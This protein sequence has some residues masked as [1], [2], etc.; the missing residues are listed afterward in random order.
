MEKVKKERKPRQPKADKPR[1][2]KPK[3]DKPKVSKPKAV[4]PKVSKPKTYKPSKNIIKLDNA[5]MGGQS[6]QNE[7]WFKPSFQKDIQIVTKELSAKIKKVQDNSK[8][9]AEEKQKKI[10]KLTATNTKVLLDLARDYKTNPEFFKK[11]A[12]K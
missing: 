4:K 6:I 8:L 7:D 9:S 12:K 10:K 5:L 3:A 2:S 11:M 1:V